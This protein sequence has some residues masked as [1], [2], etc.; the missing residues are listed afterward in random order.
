MIHF[1]CNEFTRI[2]ESEA[3]E[4]EKFDLSSDD[5]KVD[6]EVHPIYK[7]YVW[8]RDTQYQKIGYFIVE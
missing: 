2:W 3:F 5:D 1:S 8:Y 4:G 6:D 7:T